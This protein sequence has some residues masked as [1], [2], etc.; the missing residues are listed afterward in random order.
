[1]CTAH[2][3]HLGGFCTGCKFAADRISPVHNAALDL[4]AQV[5]DTCAAQSLLIKTKRCNAVSARV[6]VSHSISISAQDTQHMPAD[7][8]QKLMGHPNLVVK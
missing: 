6:S 1:M 8:L 3:T 5:L 7:K 4:S 2:G